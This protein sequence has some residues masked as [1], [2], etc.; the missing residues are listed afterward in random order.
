MLVFNVAA[1]LCNSITAT[2]ATN[3]LGN[4][5]AASLS[6]VIPIDSPL[7]GLPGQQLQIHFQLL[8]WGPQRPASRCQGLR[9]ETS[10]TVALVAWLVLETFPLPMG[11]KGGASE[12]HLRLCAVA[13]TMV[14]ME[15]SYV[16]AAWF[17]H[18]T[19]ERYQRMQQQQQMARLL[20]EGARLTTRMCSDRQ[21]VSRALLGSTP[22]RCGLWSQLYAFLSSMC[23]KQSYIAYAKRCVSRQVSV[24]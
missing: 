4:S 21:I 11:S 7:P 16:T 10:T 5:I 20:G 13:R 19:S 14:T 23:C 12:S 1:I 8:M 15:Q 3:I 9:L 6:C 22:L 2:L 24:R 18:R 17:R